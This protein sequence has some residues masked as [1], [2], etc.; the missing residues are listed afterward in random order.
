MRPVIS[1]TCCLQ[2]MFAMF[3]ETVGFSLRGLS[4]P[5]KYKLPLKQK[6]GFLRSF[7]SPS[8]SLHPSRITGDKSTS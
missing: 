3:L 1:K 8:Y 2:K 6:Q 7:T 4:F 5:S